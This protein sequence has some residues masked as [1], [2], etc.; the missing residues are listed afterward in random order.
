MIIRPMNW[1]EF[2]HYKHRSPP[3]IKLHRALLDDYEFSRLPVASRALA[4]YL[5][6]LAS[7]HKDGEIDATPEK[8]A[9]RFRHNIDEVKQAL[10]PLLESGFFELIANGKHVASVALSSC[11]QDALS[12]TETETEAEERQSSLP[13]GKPSTSTVGGTTDGLDAAKTAIAGAA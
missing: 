3:W 8:L 4:P 13:R 10:A 12:E 9:F 11:T 1:A 5:W 7:E 2:Q 6:L